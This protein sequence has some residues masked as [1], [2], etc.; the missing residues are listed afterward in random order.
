MLSSRVVSI[1]TSAT[2]I[3]GAAGSPKIL[4]VHN[5]TTHEIFLGDRN[6]TL[7]NGFHISKQEVITFEL[8]PGEEL[9]GVA[10]TT[11]SLTILEQQL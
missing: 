11:L 3:S 6:V 7:S 10:D 4:H 8:N 1:G 2:Y 9:F 5:D